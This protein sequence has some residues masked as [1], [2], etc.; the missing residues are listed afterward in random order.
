MAQS[1]TA[2]AL[3]FLTLARLESRVALGSRD[4]LP[5]RGTEE[6]QA[7]ALLGKIC[8]LLH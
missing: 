2:H 1:P 8:Q 4:D 7:V 5:K 6:E 3:L